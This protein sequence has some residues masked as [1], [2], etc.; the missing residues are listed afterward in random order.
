MFS[1]R[2]VRYA[3][4]VER[5]KK[6]NKILSHI[7]IFV[8]IC[9]LMRCFVLQTWRV[10]DDLMQPELRKADVVV[11]IPYVWIG[12]RT[13]IGL[14]GRP[15]E[16]SLVLVS[17]GA[18]T[19]VP[20]IRRTVDA[21]LRFVTL[22]R[23]SSLGGEFGENFAVPSLMRIRRI[24]QRQNGADAVILSTSASDV[25]QGVDRTVPVQEVSAPRILG[26]VVFRIWPLARIG[27]V[28]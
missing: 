11:V 10:R 23:V 24:V 26:R 6:R 13:P 15:Q 5:K 25:R 8:F 28:R 21:M 20:S 27:L 16:N 14:A 2:P 18:E 1:R 17:D 7:V 3:E 12:G 4:K 9:I 19:I 22:Q